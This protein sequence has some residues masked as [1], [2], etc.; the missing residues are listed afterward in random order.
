VPGLARET[1]KLAKPIGEKRARVPDRSR[2][3]G[4]KLRAISRTIRRRSGEAKAEVLK[5]TEQTG[6]LLER[7]VTEARRLAAVARRKARGRGA[8]AKLKAAGKL[9]ELADRCEKIARQIR[10]RVNGEKITNRIISLADPDARPIRMGKL[11]KST[12]FGYV[13]QLTEVTE[14]TKPGVRG[15][16]LPASTALGNPSENTPLPATVEEL[17]RLAIAPREVALDGRVHAHSNEHRARGPGAQASVHRRPPPTGL[18]THA[19]AV[20][21]L[22]NRRRG[23]DQP[24]ETPLRTGPIPPQGRPRPADLD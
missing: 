19:A 16:I 10:Q 4:R 23:P 18:Q 9:E 21:A 15:L 20:A 5:L 13:A 2:S 12:E 22:P 1:R 14:H 17:K 7:S 24:P 8:N 3:M 6:E 11:D